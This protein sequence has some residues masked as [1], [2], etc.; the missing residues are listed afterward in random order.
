MQTSPGTA[1]VTEAH[2]PG[3]MYSIV[4]AFDAKS[5]VTLYDI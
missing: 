4:I 1:V 5:V 3:A 2:W